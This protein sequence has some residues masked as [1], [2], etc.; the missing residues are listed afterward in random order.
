MGRALRKSAVEWRVLRNQL[1]ELGKDY[2][3]PGA[4]QLLDLVRGGAALLRDLLAGQQP[5]RLC[6]STS[7]STSIPITGTGTG[8]AA[9]I[10]KLCASMRQPG[11]PLSRPCT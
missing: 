10:L 2:S 3:Q 9:G 6:V 4:R 5:H 7:T 8:T 1:L 11:A